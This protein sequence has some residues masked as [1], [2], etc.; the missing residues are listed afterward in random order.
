MFAVIRK[1]VLSFYG[2][3]L[4]NVVGKEA[5]QPCTIKVKHPAYKAGLPGA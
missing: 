5:I 4:R 3:I 1:Y 2:N